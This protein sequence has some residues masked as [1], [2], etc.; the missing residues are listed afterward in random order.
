MTAFLTAGAVIERRKTG[1]RDDIPEDVDPEARSIRLAANDVNGTMDSICSV[2][3]V[4][5]W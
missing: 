5:W 4:S 2:Q 1:R 3:T